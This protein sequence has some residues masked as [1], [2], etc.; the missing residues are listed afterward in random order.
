M[1]KQKTISEGRETSTTVKVGKG[2]RKKELMDLFMNA[3]ISKKTIVM[4]L[5]DDVV[6]LESQLTELKKLPFIKVHP[7]MPDLQKETIAGKQ[8]KALLQQ[9]NNCIKILLTA[10]S[11]NGEDGDESPLRAYLKTLQKADF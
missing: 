9:Y 11:K 7:T 10:V 6:F 3:D 2:D 1:K 5:I 8:Y 4:P